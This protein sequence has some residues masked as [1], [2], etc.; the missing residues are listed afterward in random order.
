[1]NVKSLFKKSRRSKTDFI[2]M[3]SIIT[4]PFLFYTYNLVP[5]SKIWK[6][7]LFEIDAGY[8][9]EAKRLIWYLFVKILTLFILS[10]WYLSCLHKWKLFI[11]F[12]IIG[13]I[14]K[15][16]FVIKFVNQDL[17]SVFFIP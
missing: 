9:Q 8:Y 14:S 5:N 2:F 13:E 4:L 3:L 11:L 12:P 6:T 10:I 16:I 7:A 17:G 15:I 1:M